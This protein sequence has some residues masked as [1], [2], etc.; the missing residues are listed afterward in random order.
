MKR[1]ALIIV[2]IFLLL[3]GTAKAQNKEFGIGVILGEPT[4][5][6]LKK[7]LGGHSAI[8]GAVAW[9]FGGANS[10]HLHADYLYH[11]FNLFDV[12]SGQLPLYFG[13]GFRFKT[14][15]EA[16]FGARFPVGI[17]YIFEKAPLDIFLELGPV[18]DLVP[19][20]EFWFTGSIGAR[21]YFKK[22]S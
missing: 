9:S 6:S 22:G 7:W 11:N 4:G 18:L 10:F 2:S 1:S 20:M 16:T 5:I 14:E 17:C 8:D 13:V 12:E 21:F 3:T 19:G 15:P